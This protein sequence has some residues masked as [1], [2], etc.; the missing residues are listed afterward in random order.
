MGLE[1]ELIH[2]DN[3]KSAVL[4]LHGLTG[5]PFELKKYAQFLFNQGYDVYAPCLPG[6]GDRVSEIYTVTYQDWLCF[7]E[8][9]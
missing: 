2:E 5:T 1:F 7:V 6:H 4:L 8:N 3:Q 9:K